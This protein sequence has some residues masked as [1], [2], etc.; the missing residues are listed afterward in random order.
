MSRPL[1]RV[2]H[3]SRTLET[4]PTNGWVPHVVFAV[5]KHQL[6]PL[7][8]L[9]RPWIQMSR[10]RE[11]LRRSSPPCCKLRTARFTART[12]TAI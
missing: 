1:G 4:V 2:T 3:F 9:Q 12:T 10:I 7:T 5:H 11:V 8:V 6:E